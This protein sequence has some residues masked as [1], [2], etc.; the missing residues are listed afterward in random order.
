[1][2]VDRGGYDYQFVDTPS[3]MLLCK[4]CHFPSKEPHLSVCCGHTFCKSC[5]DGIKQRK[6]FHLFP[7]VVA[8]PMCRCEGF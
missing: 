7:K 2:S 3:D 8:C 1:M 4:I 6:P 5:L